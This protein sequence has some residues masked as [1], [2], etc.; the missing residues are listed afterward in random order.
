VEGKLG[1]AEDLD[2]RRLPHDCRGEAR[3][4][5][6]RWT[7]MRTRDWFGK[8]HGWG[9]RFEKTRAFKRLRRAVRG[10]RRFA[11][12]GG[13]GCDGRGDGPETGG[14]TRG[15]GATEWAEESSAAAVAFYV[16]D[17][18]AVAR[19]RTRVSPGRK[20]G[21]WAGRPYGLRSPWPTARTTAST[22]RR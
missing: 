14:A 2:G 6:C 5:S 11:T 21:A 13:V 15:G 20:V 17:G 10:L 8:S 18:G 9:G 12:P 19:S 7:G 16:T 1:V 3:N 4:R 22:L